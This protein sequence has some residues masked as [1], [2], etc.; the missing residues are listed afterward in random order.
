[1]IKHKLIGIYQ[2]ISGIFGI[3]L[4]LLNIGKAFENREVLFTVFLGISLFIG[5]AYAGYLL[6]ND[7]KNAVKYSITAQA[8]QSIGIIYNGT[9]YLFTGA[10][11]LSVNY[12]N[13]TFNFNYSI[14]P[15]G[16]NISEISKLI[17][18]EVTIFFIP[19][20]FILIL[21]FKR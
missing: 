21:V 16:F 7:R 11:F 15:I 6:F 19:L 20:I 13:N 9:Q 12:T 3:L 14:T 18:F 1:M 10:A 5:V 4:I 17:P 8:M 2:I